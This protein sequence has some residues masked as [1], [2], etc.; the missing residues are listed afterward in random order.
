MDGVEIAETV[1]VRPF[2]ELWD[3]FL[4]A[5][6]ISQ[7]PV[8]EQRVRDFANGAGLAVLWLAGKENLPALLLRGEKW[9][10][11]PQNL[12]QVVGLASIVLSVHYRAAGIDERTSQLA[13]G[14]CQMLSYASQSDALPPFQR[15]AAAR[16]G[17]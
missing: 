16:S 14:A 4:T 17:T 10:C 12:D 11:P 8:R 5:A 1:R 15:R 9:P 7:D 6:E 13:F 2:A 3:A